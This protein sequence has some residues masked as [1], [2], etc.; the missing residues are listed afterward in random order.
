MSSKVKQAIVQ[1]AGIALGAGL[2]YLAFKD[3]DLNQLVEALRTANYSWLFVL[4]LALL[5]SNVLRAWRWTLFLNVLPSGAGPTAPVPVK[6]AF[7]SVMIGYM[8]NN[9]VPRLGE[10]V[11]AGNLS[12][13]A[14]RPFSGVFATV[15]V[16]RV[17]DVI[18]LAFILA[19]VVFLVADEPAVRDLFLGSIEQQTSGIEWWHVALFVVVLALGAGVGLWLLQWLTKQTEGVLGKIGELARS[20]QDGL[21]TAVRSPY[22]IGIFTS[23]ILMWGCYL[24]MVYVPFLM[25]DM[26]GPFDLS[27]GDAFIVLGI[28]TIGFMI[29]SPGG[30]GSYHYAV[31]QT[32]ILLGVAEDPARTYALLTH[33]S[34]FIV[35]TVAGFACLLAQ[36]T[37]LSSALETADG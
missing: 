4:V 19:G 6:T 10:V 22:R 5:L 34:Q 24:I 30:T 35:L 25:L 12:R 15:F 37:K 2:L 7:Y 29:P 20:F 36:G 9:A 28:G 13:Q 1:F 3:T 16:E 8:V 33:G 27:W 14:S 11:R 21:M 18:V 31:I 32:L 23:T 17:L 26:V